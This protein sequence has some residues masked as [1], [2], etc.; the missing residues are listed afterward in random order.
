MVLVF[1]LAALGVSSFH[2][3]HSLARV[4]F[5]AAMLLEVDL[6]DARG[7]RRARSEAKG[8]GVGTGDEARSLPLLRRWVKWQ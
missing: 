5:L 3:C 2:P 1:T 4:A 7:D 8:A 6:G